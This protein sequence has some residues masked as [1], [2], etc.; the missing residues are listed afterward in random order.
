M[1]MKRGEVRDFGQSFEV[2]RLIEMLVDV[3]ENSVHPTVILGA[4]SGRRDVDSR[5]ISM[6]RPPQPGEAPVD[7]RPNLGL[8]P[9]NDHDVSL[10]RASLGVENQLGTTKQRNGLAGILVSNDGVP[11]LRRLAEVHGLRAT[12]NRSFLGGT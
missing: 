11:D 5:R 7:R 3:L 4:A 9:M 12:D 2:Q 10:N 1:E 8:R 6:T